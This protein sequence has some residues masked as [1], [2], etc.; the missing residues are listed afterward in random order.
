M[1]VVHL[2]TAGLTAP[3]P[4]PL[5][6]P[7]APARQILEHTEFVDDSSLK[8]FPSTKPYHK[9]CTQLK[10]LSGGKVAYV[11]PDQLALPEQYTDVDKFPDKFVVDGFIVCVDVSCDLGSSNSMQT[12]FFQKLLPNILSTK[13]PIVIAATKFDI[14]AESSVG[15]VHDVVSHCKKACPVVEVSALRGIN[16]DL[17]FLVL[18]HL[19]D[20]K[21]P[22]ARLVPY[23]DA[24]QHMDERIRRSEGDF[25]KLLDRSLSTFTLSVYQAM[26]LMEKEPELSILRDI[27]GSE[28]VRRL[29]RGKLNYLRQDRVSALRESF[30]QQLPSILATLLPSMPIDASPDYARAELE[31][32]ERCKDTFSRVE[33]WHED[34]EFLA[35]DSPLV[36]F[37]FLSEP[38]GEELVRQHI[39][40]VR[41]QPDSLAPPPS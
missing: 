19:I 38:A 15:V 40:K 36:P 3:C 17:C 28:R 18:A 21:K 10:I 29:V 25:Q 20:S 23:A 9:R 13:K 8:P 33:D 30:T 16:V 6:R 37:Q 22:K 35:Q 14:A 41:C 26:A 1:L 4:A 12:E 39:D 31:R 2:I 34:I 5:P 27:S 7:P 24:R 11:Q 32:H